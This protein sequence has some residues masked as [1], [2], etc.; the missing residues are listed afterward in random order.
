M[1]TGAVLQPRRRFVTRTRGAGV[2]SLLVVGSLAI[3][4]LQSARA[5]GDCWRTGFGPVAAT[6]GFAYELTNQCDRGVIMRVVLTEPAYLNGRETECK[7]IPAHGDRAYYSEYLGTRF[8]A[9]ACEEGQV[10]IE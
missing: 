8:A 7:L 3:V 4:P 10:P 6:P 1:G 9:K 2:F 5:D